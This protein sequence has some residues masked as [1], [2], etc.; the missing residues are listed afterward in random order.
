M[1]YNQGNQIFKENCLLHWPY[2]LAQVL[3]GQLPNMVEG[4]RIQAKHGG[5]TE[6][7]K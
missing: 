6:M 2:F 4:A 7:W 3:W 5:P 1:K